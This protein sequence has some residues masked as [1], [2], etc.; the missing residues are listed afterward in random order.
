MRCFSSETERRCSVD[1]ATSR[2]RGDTIGAG[3]VGSGPGLATRE[4]FRPV[5]PTDRAGRGGNR[6]TRRR[7]RARR[8]VASRAGSIA[9]SRAAARNGEARERPLFADTPDAALLHRRRLPELRG[10][11]FEKGAYPGPTLATSSVA[12]GRAVERDAPDVRPAERLRAAI[13]RCTALAVSPRAA[14]VELEDR[15]GLSSRSAAPRAASSGGLRPLARGTGAPGRRRNRRRRRP[16]RSRSSHG[17]GSQPNR[18]PPSRS[19]DC[20]PAS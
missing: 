20:A 16:G 17:S 9:R 10:R 5:V 3:L 1:R 4:R 6:S 2:T 15:A 11:P 14:V 18:A 12:A 7:P 8:R 19:R 13:G